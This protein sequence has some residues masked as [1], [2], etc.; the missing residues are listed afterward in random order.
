NPF[1][2]LIGRLGERELFV[3]IGLFTVIGSAAVMHQ[4]GVPPALVPFAA[5]VALAESPYGHELDSDLEP[6]RSILLGLF[7]LSVG[8]LLDL[9]LIGERP[10]LVIG[11]AAAVIVT[12]TILISGLSRLFGC[13]SK[14]S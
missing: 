11:L 8:M 1:L 2:R 5:G 12:K 10:L 6:F 13:T 7:F 14:L 9:K 4:F 3:V